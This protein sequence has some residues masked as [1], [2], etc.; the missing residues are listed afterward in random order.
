MLS[1][2]I[3]ALCLLFS[4]GCM[5]SRSNSVPHPDSV[6][7]CSITTR[8]FG[9]LS[10]GESIDEYTLSNTRG[11]RVSVLT[12]GGII[13]EIITPARDGTLA[14]IVLG[15]DSLAPYE[16]RHPYFGTI[17]G[18]FANRIAQGT[19]TLDGKTYTLARNN[20][21]NHLH[22]GIAGFDRKV[23]KAHA[24]EQGAAAFLQLQMTSPD[25]DEGYPGEV[26]TEVTYTLTSENKLRIDYVATT[27]KPTP[28][29]LTSHS[30]FNLAGHDSG[31][32]LSQIVQLFAPSY[33][34][35][36]ATLIPTGVEAPVR[37]TPFDFLKPTS[38]GARIKEVGIGYD[39][40]FIVEEHSHALRPVAHVLD[41]HSGRTLHVEST[42][43]GVQFYTGN[44]L[45]REQGKGGAV[46]QKH[47]GFCLETQNFPD[48]VNQSTF[49]SAIL[50]PGERYEH[51]TVFTFGI[52]E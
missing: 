2:I 17:T 13:R 6:S 52:Q 4:G 51:T 37:N 25:G 34:P 39:H 10:T 43:P 23:W 9:T 48:A 21:P 19:F 32:V 49:P 36:D 24:R 38:I 18:R 1:R 26:T 29:N 20:A 46:Y 47:A 28:I 35:V 45:E 3:I 27:T 30:Y 33:L 8:S 31:N 12:W 40:N 14:D 44:H 22:G 50:R 16:A 15:Y 5:G 7:T 42:Q 11:V 41:P